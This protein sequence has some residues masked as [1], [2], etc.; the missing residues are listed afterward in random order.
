MITPAWPTKC[1][2]IGDP[3]PKRQLHCAEILLHHTVI[4]EL[5]PLKDVLLA[6][7]V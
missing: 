7:N 1:L 3:F 6:H 2:F 4:V 5:G